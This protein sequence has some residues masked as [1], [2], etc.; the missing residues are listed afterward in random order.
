MEEVNTLKAT[1]EYDNKFDIMDIGAEGEFKYK[2][3]IEIDNSVYID[4][5]ENNVPF[6]LEM[7]NASRIFNIR[8][9]DLHNPKHIDMNITIKDGIIYLKITYIYETHNASVIEEVDKKVIN[10]YNISDMETVLVT[11]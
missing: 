4:F 10:D 2:K 8:K 1:Y 9:Q 5:D 6:A 3:T 11:S 7:F